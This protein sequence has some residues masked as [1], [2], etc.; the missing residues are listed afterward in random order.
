MYALIIFSF[1]ERHHEPLPAKTYTSRSLHRPIDIMSERLIRKENYDSDEWSGDDRRQ[2]IRRKK[3][4]ESECKIAE[5]YGNGLIPQELIE[6]P[7]KNDEI[8]DNYMALWASTGP[9]TTLDTSNVRRHSAGSKRAMRKLSN[10]HLRTW[11]RTAR[12]NNGASSTDEDD[13]SEDVDE[14]SNNEDED[15]V[16]DSNS[17]NPTDEESDVEEEAVETNNDNTTTNHQQKK[18]SRDVTHDDEP[19][20]GQLKRSRKDPGVEAD[21]ATTTTEHTTDS[22]DESNSQARNNERRTDNTVVA[23]RNN[24]PPQNPGRREVDRSG[25]NDPDSV[26][27]RICVEMNA[28]EQRYTAF[29]RGALRSFELSVLMDYLEKTGRE[30]TPEELNAYM[31]GLHD[32][33][34][35]DLFA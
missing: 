4:P 19:V 16:V 10:V 15:R 30:M 8:I 31:R 12:G 9:T 22:S 28:G 5:K 1:S 27:Q 33:V 14:R 35:H 25:T 17:N 32:I 29:H 24:G 6:T 2:Y 34:D 23:A 13:G 7:K 18:R 20:E 3:A 21:S 11:Q 26:Y